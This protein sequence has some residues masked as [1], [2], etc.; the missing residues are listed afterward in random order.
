MTVEKCKFYVS[1]KCAAAAPLTHAHYNCKLLHTE[2]TTIFATTHN[3]PT[4]Q[5]NTVDATSNFT[6]LYLF[7]LLTLLNYVTGDFGT[8][9]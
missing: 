7:Y 3:K 6:C 8:T 9:M 4:Y 2:Y 1:F 5:V